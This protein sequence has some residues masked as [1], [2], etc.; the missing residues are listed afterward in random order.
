MSIEYFSLGFFLKKAIDERSEC[1]YFTY[2]IA[3]MST[4]IKDLS[5]GNI[6]TIKCCCHDKHTQLEYTFHA[7]CVWKY[8]YENRYKF[9]NTD[10]RL[11]LKE[12]DITLKDSISKLSHLFSNNRKYKV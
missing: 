3:C 4:I 5:D 11:L 1:N 6:V 2:C 12:M 7:I 9:T 10:R 8:R